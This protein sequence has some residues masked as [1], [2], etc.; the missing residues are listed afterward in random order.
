MN[1][2]WMPITVGIMNLIGGIL[3]VGLSVLFIS[4]FLTAYIGSGCRIPADPGPV[5]V[6]AIHTG[7]LVLTGIPA[8]IGGIFA[9]RRERWKLSLFGSIFAFLPLSVVF[10]IATDWRFVDFQAL[11]FYVLIILLAF[12]SPVLTV[13]SRR[14]FR[15]ASD[16]NNGDYK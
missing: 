16:E 3:Q 10:I 11:P 6:L 5:V 8:I 13:L 9:L 12:A 4:V 7:P 14:Q 15:K 2:Q 1:K